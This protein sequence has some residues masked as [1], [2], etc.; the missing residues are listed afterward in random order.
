MRMP[1]AWIHAYAACFLRI[2]TLHVLSHWRYVVVERA[3]LA[4]VVIC[5][6]RPG[7]LE[8]IVMLLRVPYMSE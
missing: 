2:C 4:D 3:R 5:T 6:C 7:V 1:G 8:K